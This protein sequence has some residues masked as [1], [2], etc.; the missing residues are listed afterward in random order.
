MYLTTPQST[1]CNQEVMTTPASNEGKIHIRKAVTICQPANSHTEGNGVDAAT[2]D[3]IAPL[4]A[5][6]RGAEASTS[7]PR[8]REIDHQL[9][10]GRHSGTEEQGDKWEG[11]VSGGG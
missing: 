3:R 8:K 5:R 10:R 7:L 6:V 11:Q 1:Q 2:N 4:G 9:V